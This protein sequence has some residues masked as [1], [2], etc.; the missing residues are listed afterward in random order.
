M[1]K[2]F[3]PRSSGRRVTL[4]G[5]AVWFTSQWRDWEG[6]GEAFPRD[7]EI[8]AAQRIQMLTALG[9]SREEAEAE[10]LAWLREVRLARLG[11]T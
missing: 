11:R 7:L 4:A 3:G 5:S 9:L 1:K 6:P 2:W 10:T 8:P